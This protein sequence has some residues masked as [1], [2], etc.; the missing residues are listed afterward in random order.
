MEFVFI[1]LVQFATGEQHWMESSVTWPTKEE[2]IEAAAPMS[3]QIIQ[4][5]ADQ[6]GIPTRGYFKCIVKGTQT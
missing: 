3:H 6:T 1:L 2:C 4:D 5:A